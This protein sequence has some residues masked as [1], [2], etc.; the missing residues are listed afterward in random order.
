VSHAI[1]LSSK[2][3]VVELNIPHLHSLK[4]TGIRRLDPHP[5]DELERGRHFAIRVEGQKGILCD[6]RAV[7]FDRGRLYCGYYPVLELLLQ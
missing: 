1:A 7:G 3:V 6:P 5:D 4:E 2:Y